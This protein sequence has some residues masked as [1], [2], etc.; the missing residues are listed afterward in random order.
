MKSRAD[1]DLELVANCDLCG[2]ETFASVFGSNGW[3]LVRCTNCSLVMV[4]PRETADAMQAYYAADFYDDHA[5]Y[6]SAQLKSPR[7]DDFKIARELSALADTLELPRTRRS[8]DIGCGFGRFVEAM[9]QRQ[10]DAI[11]LEPSHRASTAA[12]DAGRRVVQGTLESIAFESASFAAVTAFHVLEHVHYPSVFL[13]RCRELLVRDG[14][15]TI[16]VPDFGCPA[17]RIAGPNWKHLHAEE[18]LHQFTR[19]TLSAM[20]ERSG[21][22]IL[23]TRRVGGRGFL[24]PQTQMKRAP[25]AKTDTTKRTDDVRS[26]LFDLRKAA[27]WIPGVQDIARWAMWELLG[28]GEA[29]RIIAVRRD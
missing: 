23:R 8:L 7:V 4:S 28:Y 12:A 24:N 19:R 10:W 21:F 18:H 1:L 20:V 22:R 9:R 17:S 5:A 25:I 3:H 11:G 27:Y 6:G 16:E 15:L 13:E 2:N 26:R 29:I 14:L